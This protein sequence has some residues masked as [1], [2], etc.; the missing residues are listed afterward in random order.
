MS[1]YRFGLGVLLPAAL[2][3]LVAAG[4]CRRAEFTFHPVEGTVT[5]GGRPL[6]NIEV[7]FLADPGSGTVGPRATGTTDAAGRYR[8]RTDQGDDGAVAGTHR[9]IVLDLGAAKRQLI[10]TFRGPLRKEAANALPEDAKRLADEPKPAKD[11]SRV[12]PGY[13]MINRTPLRA[14]VGP[15]DGVFDIAI[16]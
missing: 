15:E 5:K 12:P 9:V 7:V 16:P 13:D 11:A 1:R 14:T 3:A 10:R 8:L 6:A 2:G 4:G